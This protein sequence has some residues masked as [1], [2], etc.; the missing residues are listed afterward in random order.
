[1]KRL[2]GE[3]L[4][5]LASM[6][7]SGTMPLEIQYSTVD[8]SHFLGIEKNARAKEIAELVLWIGY[9]KWQLKTGGKDFI[10]DPVLAD[11]HN[12]EHR[13]AILKW[14]GEP[15]L[16]RNAS[17]EPVTRWDGVTRQTNP[18][19]DLVPDESARVEVFDYPFLEIHRSSAER[20]FALN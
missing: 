8:P 1:M 12:I 3:V 7:G 19:G 18:L 10:R 15:I 5:Y 4:D 6:Q 13:D 14:T 2:E 11:F 16:R 17:G 9:L 20:T